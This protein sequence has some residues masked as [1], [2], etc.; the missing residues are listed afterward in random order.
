MVFEDGEKL[1]A[2]FFCVLFMPFRLQAVTPTFCLQPLLADVHSELPQIRPLVFVVGLGFGFV[3]YGSDK[4]KQLT[5]SI[6]RN[7]A[8]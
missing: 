2:C 6:E 3:V 5:E 1:A 7:S 4:T 8:N